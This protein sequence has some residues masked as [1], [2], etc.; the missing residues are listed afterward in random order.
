M[1]GSSASTHAKYAGDVPQVAA[2]HRCIVDLASKREVTLAGYTGL[3][4]RMS[5]LEAMAS[6][7]TYDWLFSSLASLRS[8]SSNRLLLSLS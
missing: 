5:I 2:D 3:T 6:S 7:C 1:T 4:S 8:S